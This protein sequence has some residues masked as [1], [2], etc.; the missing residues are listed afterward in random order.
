MDPIEAGVFNASNWAED[1]AIVRNQVLE[2][3]DDMEQAPNTVPLVDTPDD[4]TLFEGQKW[5]WD[6]IY[7]RAVVAQNQNEPSFKNFWNPQNLSYIDIFL[8][9]LHFKWFIIVFLPSTSRS[10]KE[11]DIAPFTLGYILC[12]LGL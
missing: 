6:G 11:T 8:H 10:I 5:G 12:Y 3:D 9:C 4:D 1:I 7:C 2:V